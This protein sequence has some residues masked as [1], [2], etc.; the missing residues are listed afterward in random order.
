M[1]I[2]ITTGIYP[3]KIGGPAQYAK[4]LRE[5][6]ESR[7]LSVRVETF[8]IEDKLP[9]GVRHLLFFFKILPHVI[10]AD[11]V[12]ALDTMS[13]GLP[14][15]VASQIFFKKFFIRTGGDFLW[16]QYVERTHKKVLLKNFYQTEKTY[17][18][19][20]ENLI[21]VLTKWLLKSSS[22]VVFS[23]EWQLNIFIK[24]YGLDKQKTLVIEN[25]YGPKE[26]SEEI[27][28][29]VFVASSRNVFLKNTQVLVEVFKKLPEATLFLDQIPFSK[30]MEKLKCSYAVIVPSISEV[31]S[32]LILDAIRFNRPFICTNEI[33]IYERIKGAGLF[34]D[35]LDKENIAL[36]IKEL[37]SEEGYKKAKEKVEAFNLTHS[38]EE[39][40]DEFLD[41]FKRI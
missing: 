3:P 14:T 33:G 15:A 35:P 13:V 31:S 40:V 17:F 11:R 25:Y 6:F 1:K 38:W 7:Q 34:V 29:P 39:I 36:A 27:N 20:K 24:A 21:F 18:S 23:T 32:N 19:F 4:R 30:F 16:E 5:Q 37:L 26:S 2:L 9:T 28:S 22:C 41:I 10:W 8:N 12:I